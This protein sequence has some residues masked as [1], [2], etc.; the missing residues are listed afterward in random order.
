VSYVEHL[1]SQKEFQNAFFDNMHT[2]VSDVATFALRKEFADERMD[3]F[4]GDVAS[5]ALQDESAMEGILESGKTMDCANTLIG[6]GSIS[7]N[8]I[9]TN[10]THTNLLQGLKS[11]K[12]VIG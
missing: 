3:T 10:L 8:S 11:M 6:L 7:A 4:V 2:F 12:W 5:Y 9:G 1:K